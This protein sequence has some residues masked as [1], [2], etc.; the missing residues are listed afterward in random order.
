MTWKELKDKI[1][2]MTEEKLQQQIP[3][4]GDILALADAAQAD[5]KDR[6]V[7]FE[8]ALNLL[9]E[10]HP[11][12]KEIRYMM[13]DKSN[14]DK[15][16]YAYCQLKIIALALNEWENETC[17]VAGRRYYPVFNIS[18]RP[19]YFSSSSSRYTSP[20]AGAL[21]SFYLSYDT[22][23]ENVC[24]DLNLAFKSKELAEYAGMRFIDIYSRFIL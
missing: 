4:G 18:E 16:T 19:I 12:V 24:F 23:G 22:V 8:D 13:G 17:K 5:I 10:N 3:A 14:F 21:T 1:S 6:V 9:G 2:R 7:V 20:S 11:L 15:S